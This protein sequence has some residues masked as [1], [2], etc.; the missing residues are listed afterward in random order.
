[1][2]LLRLTW[3]K[4]T[5]SEWEQSLMDSYLSCDKEKL[6]LDLIRLFKMGVSKTRP[7]QM[8]VI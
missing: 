8:M 4:V 1:M 7:V 5:T 6:I 2:K 3:I